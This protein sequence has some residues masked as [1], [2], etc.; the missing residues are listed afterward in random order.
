MTDKL[1]PKNCK[2]AEM[3]HETEPRSYE[4]LYENVTALSD[5]QINGAWM[6]LFLFWSK[7]Q[8][9]RTHETQVKLQVIPYPEQNQGKGKDELQNTIRRERSDEH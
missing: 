6:F 5:S 7:R 2:W 9:K 8:P 1:S 4:R 3:S